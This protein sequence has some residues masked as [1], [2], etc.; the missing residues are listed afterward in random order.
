[1]NIGRSIGRLGLFVL[2]L[3]AGVGAAH[4]QATRTWV[5]G[6]G[7]DV[8]PCSR[9]APCK[10]F[11]GAISK[12]A[13][14]GII[15][16]LDPGGFGAL[17][18]TKSIT[19]EADGDLGST[20][21]SGVNGFIINITDAVA[22]PVPSVVLRGLSIDGTG[23]GGQPTGVDGV[24]FLAGAK[25]TID[26]CSIQNFTQNGINFQP[27]GAAQLVVVNSRITRANNA[28]V[29]VQAGASG[30]A[31]VALSNVQLVNSNNGILVNKG[32]V[33]GRELTISGNSSA[34]LNAVGSSAVSRINVDSTLLSDN[35]FGVNVFGAQAN[36]FL[37]NTTVT[38]N[39]TAVQNLGGIVNTFG[40][41]RIFANTSAGSA[42]TPIA[43]Q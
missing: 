20:L 19:I 7:D 39:S 42:L 28:A 15:S 18:I 35:G 22:N 38:N 11:A 13:A 26:R 10:T 43:Q 34:G 30:A 6:V 21:A 8:N 27:A 17:T 1:M 23:A 31:S 25:L 40:N 37:S 5:S 3:I 41:N 29:F 12:T 4:A 2:L 16:V 24:R 33:S 36:V 14:G 32:T 9:T